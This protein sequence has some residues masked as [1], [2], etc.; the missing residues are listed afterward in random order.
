MIESFWLLFL[1]RVLD[2][3]RFEL[4][5]VTLVLLSRSLQDHV[6]SLRLEVWVLRARFLLVLARE[7]RGVPI[8]PLLVFRAFSKRSR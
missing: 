2:M 3:S 4:A 5:F 7:G 6:F 1:L 8:Q